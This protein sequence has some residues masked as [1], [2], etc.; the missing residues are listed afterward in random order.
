MELIKAIEKERNSR[1]LVY[2]TGDRRGLETRIA[3]DAFPMF[4]EHLSRMGKQKRIDLFL[5][6]TGG[7]TIAGYALV[8]LIR[9]FCEEFNVIIPFKALSC[10]TLISLGANEIVMTP[11][12]QLSPIDP[13]VHHPLAP[14]IQLPGQP[15]GQLIPVNVEDVNAF[16]NLA[17]EVG[18][19]NE[20]SMTKIFELLATKIHPLVLGAIQR[21]REQIAFLASNLL[22]Y[23]IKDDDKIR[24]IVE[25]ISRERFSHEYII[26]RR[27]AK[28]VLGLNIKEPE[29]NLLRNITSLFE[30]YSKILEL[31]IPYNPEMY[32]SGSGIA[33]SEFNRAIIESDDLTHIFRTI[34]EI[35]RIE[36]P[37]Q[38]PHIPVPTVGY[39]ERILRE[40]WVLDNTI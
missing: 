6:S 29:G 16:V 14:A 31:D 19:K 34:K 11:M 40:G 7:I 32:L 24:K 17:K 25:I 23:H 9:E 30:V 21:S 39:Q 20:E 1:L 13:S 18:L 33:T 12:G 38:P 2:I 27:E 10:A 37:P 28:E 26:S 15:V 4:H 8:N 22:R 3:T 35:K 36:V 5:Y